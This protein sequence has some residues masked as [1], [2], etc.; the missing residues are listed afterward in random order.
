MNTLLQKA[1]KQL[2]TKN[3]ITFFRNFTQ[4]NEESQHNMTLLIKF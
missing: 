4:N 1:T 3:G 2:E